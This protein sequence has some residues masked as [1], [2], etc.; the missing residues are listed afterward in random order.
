MK[1][2]ELQG[3]EDPGNIDRRISFLSML[4]SQAELKCQHISDLRQ[5]NMNYAIVIFAG[6]FAY[7]AKFS[8]QPSSLVA[9]VA[10]C[11][12][13]VVF[14][15]LDRR[16]H[17]INHGWRATRKSYIKQVTKLINSPA[18]TFSYQTYVAE[19]ERTAEY[20]ALQPVVYYFIIAGSLAHVLYLVLW[21]T[22]DA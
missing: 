8:T 7:A 2:Y 15:K 16:Y 17:K 4:L 12:L 13:M 9:S 21:A 18:Q 20:F 19:G 14:C 3:A 22:P 11:C 10:L 6:L 5:R 1:D